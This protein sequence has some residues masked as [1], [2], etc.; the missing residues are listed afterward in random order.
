MT[1]TR[2]AIIHFHPHAHPSAHTSFNSFTC[3]NVFNTCK[4][5]ACRNCGC[6]HNSH[7][8]KTERGIPR[9]AI[10]TYWQ[11]EREREI[12]RD[13]QV[14][15]DTGIFGLFLFV[16]LY[17][18]LKWFEKKPCQIP[19]LL[20]WYVGLCWTKRLSVTSSLFVWWW[21]FLVQTL[22]CSGARQLQ[23]HS[24]ERRGNC[25]WHN[26]LFELLT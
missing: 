20:D 24:E 11:R 25:T 16:F 18:K 12:E 22:P 9:P 8:H 7:V 26:R 23:Q 1:C 4:S 17:G 19:P 13:L 15:Q 10:C 21:L 14:F 2:S 6:T 5:H 3:T